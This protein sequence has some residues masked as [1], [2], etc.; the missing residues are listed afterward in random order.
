M[1]K[2]VLWFYAVFLVLLLLGI[3]FDNQ[4]AVFLANNRI[5]FLIGLMNVF[6]FVGEGVMVFIL[7]TIIFLIARKTKKL[8]F[9]WLSIIISAILTQVLKVI[10][11][12]QRPDVALYVKNSFSFPSGHATS[13]FSVLAVIWKEIP[14]LKWF[15]L[16]FAVVVAF[17]RLYL[18]LHYLTDV[19]V[20]A[21][22]G[23]SV[24][25]IIVKYEKK[26]SGLFKRLL[27]RK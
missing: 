6:S 8:P 14:W 11:M 12:R 17:S 7:T 26:I 2:K 19:V 3:F 25:L 16:V 9:L 24:S 4:L 27:R 13:V 23:F 18:G 22:I 21:L 1:K 10:I 20:G 15:W 5:A